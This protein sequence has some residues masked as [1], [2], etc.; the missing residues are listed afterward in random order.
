MCALLKVKGLEP[1][2]KEAGP[3]LGVQVW[4]VPDGPEVANSTPLKR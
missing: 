3:D 1:A 2:G 4:A